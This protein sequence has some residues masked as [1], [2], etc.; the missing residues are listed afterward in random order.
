MENSTC[1]ICKAESEDL[2]HVLIECSHAKQFWSA[3]KEILLLK[4]PKLHPLTWTKDILC[5]PRYTPDERAKIITVMY[6]IWTSRNNITHGEMGYNPAKSMEFISETLSLLEM[7][8]KTPTKEARRASQWSR[9]TQGFVKINLDGAIQE[10]ESRAATGAVARDNVSFRGAMTKVY[11]GVLD[12]LT[13]ETLALR[14]ACA[15]AI[16]KGFDRVVLSTDCQVLL[17]H[18]EE[19]NRQRS[20]IGPILD[21]ISE[22]KSAFS[23]FHFMYEGREANQVAHCCAKFAAINGEPNTWDAEPPPWLVHSLRADCNSV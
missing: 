12:A 5:D 21:E 10:E 11:D 16:Q 3:A 20:M 14:D 9:P 15:Y 6:N 2:M 4:L 17:K 13:V 19:R 18:W 7:P 1:G 23:S 8:K 22:M